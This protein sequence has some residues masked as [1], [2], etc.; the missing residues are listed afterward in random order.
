MAAEGSCNAFRYEPTKR[1]PQSLPELRSP[2]LTDE[3]FAI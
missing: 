3:D 2:E 1:E